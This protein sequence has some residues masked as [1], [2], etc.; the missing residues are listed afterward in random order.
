MDLLDSLVLLEDSTRFL[1]GVSGHDPVIL[2]GAS[3]VLLSLLDYK[4]PGEA[5]DGAL[6]WESESRN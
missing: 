3:L 4:A 6:R 1:Y 5:H 2:I